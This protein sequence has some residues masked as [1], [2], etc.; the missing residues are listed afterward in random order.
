MSVPTSP[1]QRLPDGWS[2][3]EVVADVIVADGLALARSGVAAKSPRGEE[4]TGSAAD[5]TG[6]PAARS[7]YEL[8][9]RVAILEAMGSTDTMLPVRDAAGA[10]IASI[11]RP[12]AFPESD[13]PSTWRYA[14]SNGIALHADWTTAA[15]RAKCELVERDRVL[16][17]WLGEILPER[18]ELSTEDAPL[19][20]TRSYQWEAYAFRPC[21]H[22]DLDPEIAVVGVFGFPS[23]DDVPL[24]VGYAGRPNHV[25]ACNSAMREALQQLAFLWGEPI[26]T[27]APQMGPTALHH[28]E[29]WQYRGHHRVLRRWLSGAHA[30]H[31]RPRSD[32][33]SSTVRYVDL[34]PAWMTEHR[35]VKAVCPEGTPLAFGLS[36]V[37]AHLPEELRVHPIS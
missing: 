33:G 14:R 22:G 5:A 31:A 17:S 24:V 1:P 16:R 6:E 26:P 29:Y 19:A 18:V 10:A 28:L 21:P 13:D 11:D 8:L 32:V 36:P 2:E 3:P 27:E 12:S 15:L 30:R 9:E 35:V 25:D 4:V 23:A 34:T 37:T 20:A 7:Y